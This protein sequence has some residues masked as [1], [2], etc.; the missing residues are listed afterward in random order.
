M[1]FRNRLTLFFVAIVIVPMLSVAFVLF[2]LIEDNEDGK[3]DSRLAARQQLAVNLYR[4]DVEQAGKQA[5]R[6]GGDQRLA[7]AL[8]SG[9]DVAARERATALLDELGLVRIRIEDRRGERLDVG[10]RDA[11]APARR[12]LLDGRGSRFGTLEVSDRSAPVFARQV[13]RLAGID[14]VVRQG[15]RTLAETLPGVPSDELP[16]VGDTTVGEDDYRVASFPAPGFADG[17]VRVSVLSSTDAV[18]SDIARSR[19]LAGGVL[20]GFFVLAMWC[21][22]LVS[23]SLQA[24]IGAFLEAARRL[25]RGDFTAQVPTQGRDEFAALG[26]EFNRMARLLESRL[27]DLRTERLRLENAMRRLGEAFA[28][29]LDRK[30]LLEI[31]VRTAVDGVDADGGRAMLTADGAEAARF[32][33]LDGLDS[34]V[35]QVESESAVAVE[36]REASADGASALAHPLRAAAGGEVL[37]VVSVWRRGGPFSDAERELFHY[38]AAQAAVSLDNVALHETVQRQAVTDELTGLFNHRRFHEGLRAEVERAR[39]FEQ[40]LGLVMLDIDNFKQVNDT[41]GHQVGDR[42]LAEVARVLRDNSR[43]IDEPARYGGEELAVVLPGTDLEGAYNLAE[44]VRTGVERLDLPLDDGRVLHVTASF[45]AASMPESA[46]DQSSLIAAADTALYVAKRSGKNRTA[47]AE[48][49]R[50]RPSQ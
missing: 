46:N 21:A 9:D 33:D 41:Y 16:R 24:Q 7:T 11:V 36:P 27:E 19:L 3:A 25:G 44:R 10:R 23:R 1:S 42:V 8:R 39:R 6:V 47:R 37:G 2:S 49:E 45:G 4:E 43:E 12:Q 26:G 34:V 50:A 31:A 18:Q 17:E 28:S 38:L 35:G 13:E 5:A 48:P 29:N 20:A 30:A 15:G 40:G 32:G 22:V 14:V